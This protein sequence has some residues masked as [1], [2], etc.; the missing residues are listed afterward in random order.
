MTLPA[1]IEPRLDHST[2]EAAA[3]LGKHGLSFRFVSGAAMRDDEGRHPAKT[4]APPIKVDIQIIELLRAGPKSQKQLS[5][6]IQCC[7]ATVSNAM[8]SLRER[9]LVRIW[10][11]EDHKAGR[12]V[13]IW[14]IVG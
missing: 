7:K 6:A 9:E 5:D 8:A 13:A 12:A 14:E 11:W 3:M 4:P 2:L 10:K 1:W